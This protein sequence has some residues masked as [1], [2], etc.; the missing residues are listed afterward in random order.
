MFLV[1]LIMGLLSVALG[2]YAVREIVGA[3]DPKVGVV[4]V[5]L[6]VTAMFGL[7]EALRTHPKR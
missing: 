6:L 3:T 1:R 7:V 4:A 5:L 2:A